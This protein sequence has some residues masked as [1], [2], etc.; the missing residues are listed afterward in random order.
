MSGKGLEDIMETIY[1]MSPKTSLVG[2]LRS[3]LFLEFVKKDLQQINRYL[4]KKNVLILDLGCQT[5]YITAYLSSKGFS[6]IG[7]DPMVSRRQMRLW[8]KLA[9]RSKASFIVG[10][11]K[12]LPLKDRIFEAVICYAVIEHIHDNDSVLAESHRVLDGG[13]LFFIFGLPKRR[14]YTERLAG[15][16]GLWHHENL[17][18]KG[19]IGN[20]LKK[21][22]FQ[23]EELKDVNVLP[24]SV[25]VWNMAYL[26]ILLFYIERL[27]VKTP[28][29]L[30]SHSLTV[31]SRKRD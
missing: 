27:L 21:H 30:V 3:K 9:S 29:K 12:C 25:E 19:E 5:G 17:Y 24:R 2:R 1:K 11:G 14:S 13:G 15:T 4:K 31:V 22:G 28:L 10:D 8:R 26:W 20:L 16:L 23:V 6:V 7:L 18:D